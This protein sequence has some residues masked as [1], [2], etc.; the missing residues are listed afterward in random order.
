MCYDLATGRMKTG[1]I[2]CKAYKRQYALVLVR[3]VRPAH[4]PGGEPCESS[5]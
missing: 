2:T 3:P 4:L 5:E 1:N